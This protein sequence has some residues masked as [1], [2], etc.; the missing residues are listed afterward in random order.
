MNIFASLFLENVELEFPEEF[1]SH[2][3]W[4]QDRPNKKTNNSNSYMN[5]FASLFLENVELEFPEEFRSHFLWLQD[6]PNKKTNNSNSYM[7]IF[8]SLF[9]ENVEL[10]FLSFGFRIGLIRKQIIPIHI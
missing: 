2:F 9:L 5:I 1:R 8:A 3:L 4:L 6:R 7:N 10:E